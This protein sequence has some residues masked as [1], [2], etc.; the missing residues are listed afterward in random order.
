MFITPDLGWRKLCLSLLV[1]NTFVCAYTNSMFSWFFF[2]PFIT[3]NRVPFGGEPF[4]VDVMGPKGL[5]PGWF[6]TFVEMI[7]DW[8]HV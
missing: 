7:W 8:M 5:I 3:G 4:F 1:C 2:P 6:S